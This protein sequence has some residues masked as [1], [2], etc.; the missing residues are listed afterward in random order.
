[1]ISVPPF[2]IQDRGLLSRFQYGRKAEP[3]GGGGLVDERKKKDAAE[4]WLWLGAGFLYPHL[5]SQFNIIQRKGGQWQWLP[6]SFKYDA[7][8]IIS[9]GSASPF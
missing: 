7:K 3:G 5:S 4:V 6:S 2:P 1:L 9:A 8:I